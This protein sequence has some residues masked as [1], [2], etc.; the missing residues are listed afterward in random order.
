MQK[1]KF[2][3]EDEQFF[4]ACGYSANDI[5]QIK[6]L[7]YEVF[8]INNDKVSFENLLEFTRREDF[9]SA[10]GRAAFHCSAALTLNNKVFYSI[11][12]NVLHI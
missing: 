7:S 6:S 4:T 11:E 5:M 9:L 10:I 2:T 8:Y 12:S 1:I 3:P